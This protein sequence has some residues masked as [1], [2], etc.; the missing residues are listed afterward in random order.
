MISHLGPPKIMCYFNLVTVY[1]KTTWWETN[2]ADV[3][4]QLTT[5]NFNVLQFFEYFSLALNF[6]LCLDVLLTMRQPFYPHDRR[7]KHYLP[8]SIAIAIVAF[9]VTLKRVSAPAKIGDGLDMNQ[10]AL[11]SVVFM[12]LYIIYA[13]TSVAYAWRINTREGMST[14]VRKQ[15][16]VR[17]ALYVSA[18]ILTWLPYYG[19]SYFVLYATTVKGHDISYLDIA[20]D[21]RFDTSLVK[22]FTAYNVTCIVTGILMSI[23]RVTE[24]IFKAIIKR[25]VYEFFG[26]LSTDDDGSNQSIDN[27]LLSFL[28]SSLN[29]EL[30]HIILTTV[31]KNTVGTP[32]SDANYKVYQ[33]YDHSNKNEFVLDSITIEDRQ[34]WDINQV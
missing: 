34:Q 14:H 19:F 23:I 31:S 12:T 32:K 27:T 1:Q 21:P 5:S 4:E 3:I 24:P 2:E 26:E 11:F 18:Y 22:W 20:T 33:N 7:M 13:V 15:F 9:T 6:F 8:G 29:I 28:M 16:I 25:N 17:H 10:R 30:V